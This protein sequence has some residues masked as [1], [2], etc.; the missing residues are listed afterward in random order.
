VLGKFRLAIGKAKFY[1]VSHFSWRSP[2]TKEQDLN[3]GSRQSIRNSV[4]MAVI[5][6]LVERQIAGW[7][8][9]SRVRSK[10]GFATKIPKLKGGARY[11][12]HKK[13]LN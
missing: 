1:T 11:P 7:Q 10:A 2:S 3:S 13:N 8:E 12:S 4:M 6:S 9:V 5:V